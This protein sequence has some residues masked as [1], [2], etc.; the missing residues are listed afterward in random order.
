MKEK[1]SFEENLK[2][3]AKNE[4][5][6]YAQTSISVDFLYKTCY[7]N[8]KNQYRQHKLEVRFELP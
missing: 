2:K 6:G 8:N 4:K 1:N 5:N 3:E 7:Q